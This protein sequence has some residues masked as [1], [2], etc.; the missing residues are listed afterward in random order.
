MLFG[1]LFTLL[2]L[3]QPL[4]EAGP[5]YDTLEAMREA[6]PQTPA[7]EMQ[8]AETI[9]RA[10]D[11]NPNEE[12][13]TRIRAYETAGSIY[14]REND[15]EAAA[16]IFL[17]QMQEAE[18]RGDNGESVRSL[19]NL[20]N[21][22]E[23]AKFPAQDVLDFYDATEA[24]LQNPPPGEEANYGNLLHELYRERVGRLG[25]YSREAASAEERQSYEEQ[26]AYFDQ[27]AQGM[28]VQPREIHITLADI[29]QHW[30][31]KKAARAEAAPV[32]ADASAQAPP[33]EAVKQPPTPKPAPP[34]EPL[35]PLP[36]LEKPTA[37]DPAPAAPA[38][39]IPTEVIIGACAVV[40][41]AG[42][43]L[44]AYLYLRRNR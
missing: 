37:S 15:Y 41:L 17:Q 30:I 38:G 13:S 3:A 10:L 20:I 32:A 18:Q 27:L 33:A 40:I 19:D 29:A 14:W 12:W 24:W 8:W 1:T 22:Y 35:A 2:V 39:G 6:N 34:V 16:P 11:E 21:L 5:I 4:P 36:P 31:E 25:Q 23:E 44:A 42:W 7:E 9:L 28:E 43:G 26:A